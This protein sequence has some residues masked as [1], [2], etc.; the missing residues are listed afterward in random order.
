MTDRKCTHSKRIVEDNSY[1]P[2]YGGWIE[3]IRTVEVTTYED[4]DLHRFRCTQCGHIR[5]YSARAQDHYEGVK[6]DPSI[7]E[8]NRRYMKNKS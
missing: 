5:Y 8:S 3:D 7:D 2:W 4:I 6:R 1:E